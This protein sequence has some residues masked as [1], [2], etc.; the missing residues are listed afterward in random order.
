MATC[1]PTKTT[2]GR[3]DA[4]RSS[5]WPVRRVA[6]PSPCSAART[7]TGR[8]A[9]DSRR[10]A[11][12]PPMSPGDVR[13]LVHGGSDGVDALIE[14]LVLVT[15]KWVCP[16]TKPGRTEA[17]LTS[18]SSIS[19]RAWARRSAVL[20]TLTTL[21]PARRSASPRGTSSSRVTTLAFVS[22]SGGEVDAGWGFVLL[23]VS[24]HRRPA[25]FSSVSLATKRPRRSTPSASTSSCAA[26]V[27]R[28]QP[29]PSPPKATPGT[30]PTFRAPAR[31]ARS[32]TSPD[33]LG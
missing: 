14:L 13:R 23:S 18:S 11:P 4:N 28:T 32:S 1:R 29:S 17:P 21:P 15:S 6:P 22:R 12:S 8:R 26:S 7:T 19:P 5:S 16:S 10:R 2:R 3:S 24:R 27:T 25:R 20:P 9:T 30:T 31:D 33:P